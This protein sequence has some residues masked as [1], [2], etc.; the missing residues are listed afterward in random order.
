MARGEIERASDARKR[1]CVREALAKGARA[2]VRDDVWW[3]SFE[4]LTAEVAAVGSRA[5]GMMTHSMAHN[6]MCT[7]SDGCP[8]LNINYMTRATG[9][10]RSRVASPAEVVVSLALRCRRE[11]EA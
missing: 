1:L 3:S 5:G 8:K 2:V 7:R 6:A 11:R 4:R 10:A 9:G